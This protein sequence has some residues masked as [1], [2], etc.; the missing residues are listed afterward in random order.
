VTSRGFKFVLVVAYAAV[1]AMATLAPLP[2]DAYDVADSLI[3]DKVVHFLLFG[4]LAGLL[5]TFK[6]GGGQLPEGAVIVTVAAAALVELIQMP[7][8]YRTGDWWDLLWGAGGALIAVI[9]VVR[10]RGWWE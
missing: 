4:G 5:C 7:L 1:V 10:V 2:A 6:V 3:S 8:P 9:A